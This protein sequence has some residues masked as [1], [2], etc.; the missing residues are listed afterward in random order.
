MLNTKET[1]P[2]IQDN[3]VSKE[4]YKKINII[5]LYSFCSFVMTIGNKFLV[6]EFS[7]PLI[8]SFI[9][10]VGAILIILFPTFFRQI[11]FETW[12]DVWRWSR[13][14]STTFLLILVSN[15]FAMKHI[16]LGMQIVLRNLNPIITVIFDK[17][18]FDYNTKFYSLIALLSIVPGTILY[19]KG[20]F[21]YNYTGMFWISV[22]IISTSAQRIIQKKLLCEKN[23]VKMSKMSMTFFNNFF[24]LL[25]LI[26]L[27]YFYE[28]NYV[29]KTSIFY[30]KKWNHTM[31]VLMFLTSVVGFSIGYIGISA[32]EIMSSSSM[33]V[34]VNSNKFLTILFSIYFMN[35]TSTLKS[36]VGCIL[37]LLSTCCYGYIQLVDHT[38]DKKTMFLSS[39]MLTLYFFIT[40]YV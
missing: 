27:I 7:V 25:L 40:L 3:Y 35:E 23:G 4:L 22:N 6:S 36:I 16:S 21:S 28:Y 29:F 26:P 11:K 1:D 20:N 15:M 32:Q 12:Y 18:F 8:L 31:T 5:F 38:I 10:V 14:M 2:L 39:A 24:S 13:S 9:Q 33:L 34:L 17:W 37:S 30:K 19:A